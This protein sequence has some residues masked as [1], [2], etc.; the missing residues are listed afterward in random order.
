MRPAFRPRPGPDPGPLRHA[1]RGPGSGPG[2]R[3]AGARRVRSTRHHF[4]FV[5]LADDAARLFADL[6]LPDPMLQRLNPTKSRDPG[7]LAGSYDATTK[8]MV[9]A[10]YG[11]DFERFGYARE[12]PAGVA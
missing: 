6:G 12:V 4:L 10:I 8:A 5:D 2:R 7:G 1:D 3:G 9:E 11:D